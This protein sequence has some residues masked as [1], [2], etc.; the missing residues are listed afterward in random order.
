MS[1]NQTSYELRHPVSSDNMAAWHPGSL[2]VDA[3][4]VNLIGENNPA[5]SSDG[6]LLL[7]YFKDTFL[8]YYFI[9]R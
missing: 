6:T 1:L 2:F 4:R 7:G 9:I 5:D 3:V 8:L